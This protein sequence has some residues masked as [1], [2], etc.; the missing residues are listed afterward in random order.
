MGE[1]WVLDY[2]SQLNL[3]FCYMG[4]TNWNTLINFDCLGWQFYQTSKW[5][6]ILQGS[7]YENSSDGWGD[8]EIA[9]KR[10]EQTLVRLG[11]E[12]IRVKNHLSEI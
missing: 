5:M 10:P 4:K 11:M 6:G 2:N 7:I 3:G 9:Q 12:K 8:R 1:I